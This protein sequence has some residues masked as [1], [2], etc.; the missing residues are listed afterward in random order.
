MTHPY[1]PLARLG[2]MCLFALCGLMSACSTVTL[3]K[4]CSANHLMGRWTAHIDGQPQPWTL[5]LGPHPEHLGS[6]RGTL[7]QGT[8]SYPVVADL[9]EG[10]F[11]MEESH[12]GQ[13]IA[14]TWLGQASG[15]NCGKNLQG[16]RQMSGQ[17]Q[18]GFRLIRQ[19]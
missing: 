2:L 5:T 6:L 7:T 11:T 16:H 9:D 12:D 1:S 8:L 10:E 4:E 17:R 13:R 18:H 14:A 15:A 19:P 3:E